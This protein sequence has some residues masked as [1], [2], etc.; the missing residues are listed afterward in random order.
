MDFSLDQLQTI[1]QEVTEQQDLEKE[2]VLDHKYQVIAHSDR[3]EI[4]KNYLEEGG[5]F[6]S[7]L[8]SE[9]RGTDEGSFSVSYGGA[10]Y[11]VYVVPV[12]NEWLCVSVFNTTTIFAQM[13][14][15]VLFTILTSLA[16]VL[17]LLLI[18]VRS[19]RKEEQSAHLSRVVEVLAA[20]IDAKDAYTNGH[21]GRVAEYA[22]EIGRR[23]GFTKKQQDELYMMGLL[24]DVGKIG[25]PDAVIKKPGKLTDEE[26]E[27]IRTH[28]VIGEQMLPKT[29][30][31]ARMAIGVRWHHERYDGAGYPDGLSGK[32]IP[33]QARIIAVADAYDAMTSSRSYRD[34]LEKDAVRQELLN[35][36]GTQFDPVFAGVMLQIMEEN[37]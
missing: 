15:M 2:I 3:S 30:E 17:I 27:V 29:A 28:P 36:K 24:H 12:S 31:M 7:V 34:V 37:A 14:S 5:T 10:D 1:M 8:V 16:V 26:I 20:A 6:G 35:G 32:D 13:R 11:I 21:S 25:V 23:C 33:E 18:L 4:G 22:R 9:L 19:N